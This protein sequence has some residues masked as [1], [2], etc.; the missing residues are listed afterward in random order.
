MKNFTIIKIG[1]SV[2]VYGCSGEYFTMIYTHKKEL[3]SL[4]FYGLY[5]AEE[6]VE[7]AM[8]EKGYIFNYVQ[9]FF[10]KMTRKD[11]TKNCVSERDALN[12]IK[13]I[14]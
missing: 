5:G 3:K 12:L 6:R 11:L 7:R 14:K 13:Y 10:G 4:S 2:G 8:K 1:Y 9:S